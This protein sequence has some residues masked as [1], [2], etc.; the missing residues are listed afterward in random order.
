MSKESLIEDIKTDCDVARQS[1]ERD[2]YRSVGLE[3]PGKAWLLNF[4]WVESAKVEEEGG[5]SH[6]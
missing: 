1:L 3:G 6:I 4:D 5:E 2:A